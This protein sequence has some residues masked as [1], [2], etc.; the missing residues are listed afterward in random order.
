[1]IDRRLDVG[2]VL[3]LEICRSRRARVVLPEEDGPDR[4]TMRVLILEVFAPV[5]LA[6]VV[7]R[8]L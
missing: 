4:P 6:D 7:A 2:L 8:A 3:T 5:M 1:M